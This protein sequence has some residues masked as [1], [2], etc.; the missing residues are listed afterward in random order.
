MAAANFPKPGTREFDTSVAAV[1]RFCKSHARTCGERKWLFF[2]Y[3]DFS[4]LGKKL[5]DARIARGKSL[6]DVAES[7]DISPATLSRIERDKQSLDLDL[8]MTLARILEMPARLFF[9]GDGD[10]DAEPLAARI[11]S[12]TTLQRTDLWNDLSMHASHG[13]AHSKSEQSVASLLE[14]LLAHADF[15]RG[16]IERVRKDLKRR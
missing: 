12:M 16:E 14:E 3:H 8:F 2:R 9:D 4:M 11:R 15:L 7:A 10:G 13:R 1:C 6:S 5:R